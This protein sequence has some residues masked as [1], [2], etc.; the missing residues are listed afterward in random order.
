MAPN[1]LSKS[2]KIVVIDHHI[3]VE[4]IDCQIFSYQEASASSTCE[5]LAEMIKY[6][7]RKIL[8][9]PETATLMLT[10]IL[11]D[12]N[13]YRV[14]TGTRTYDASIIL[15]EYNADHNQALEFLKDEYEEFILKNRIMANSSTPYYGVIVS[16]AYEEDLID[17]ATLAKVAQEALFIKGIKTIFVIGRISEDQ[18]GVS[19][20]S[21]GSNNV[22]L[23]MEKMGGGG[24]FS[25]AATQKDGATIDEVEQELNDILEVYI[26]DSR[27]EQ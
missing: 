12:T 24:H 27:I 3:G 2:T 23:I 9:S 7:D 17:K 16:K 18:V 13:N 8:I 25:A 21:D 19:A 10:G 20:R 6:N 4:K 22:G 11:L 5:I 14:R 15:K 26:G 1:V